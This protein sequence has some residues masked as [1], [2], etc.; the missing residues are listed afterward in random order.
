METNFLI[1][2]LAALIPLIMGFIWYGPLLF[3]N[4]WM[5]Q[6]G[7]TEES[8]KG[9]NMALI[10]ILCYVFSFL[11][12]FFLQFIVIHQTGVY[13]SLMESGA[14][15]LSGDALTYF[16]DFMAKYGNNFRTFKHGALHGTMIG[17]LIVIPIFGTNAIFEKR[18]F[19]Y[20]MIN[21]GYWVVSL[22]LMGGILCQFV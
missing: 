6:L 7:F 3:Q 22:A 14:T 1:F 10:F 17:L 5:K 19:K 9:G 11:M 12:A 13:S 20:V 16:N 4:A 2:A 15:E 8:L 21:G 18:T